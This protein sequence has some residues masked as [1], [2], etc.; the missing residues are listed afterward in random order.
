MKFKL[1]EFIQT[2]R[3]KP[4]LPVKTSNSHVMKRIQY[5]IDVEFNMTTNIS[6]ISRWLETLET[7]DTHMLEFESSTIVGTLIK[8]FTIK[9]ESIDMQHQTVRKLLSSQIDDKFDFKVTDYISVQYDMVSITSKPLVVKVIKHPLMKRN[10]VISEFGVH[11]EYYLMLI[12]ISKFEWVIDTQGSDVYLKSINISSTNP[13]SVSHDNNIPISQ[14]VF[15]LPNNQK[16]PTSEYDRKSKTFL[17]TVNGVK[18]KIDISSCPFLMKLF[19]VHLTPTSEEW[20]IKDN[21]KTNQL[22]VTNTS[23]KIEKDMKSKMDKFANSTKR[24]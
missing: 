4:K 20:F 19:D 2:E 5:T 16:I 1:S 9:L 18:Y 13:I 12:Q 14:D 22:Q 8:S 6:N 7:L 3:V 24:K 17:T 23:F 10:I 11:D 15:N 21:I